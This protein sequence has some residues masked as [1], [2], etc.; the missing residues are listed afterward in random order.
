GHTVA[1]RD[2]PTAATVTK[3][4]ATGQP[5]AG[6][7]YRVEAAEGSAFAD[8]TTERSLVADGDDA[9]GELRGQ[10]VVGD[11]YRMVETAAPA[12]YYLNDEALDFT[13]NRDG[14]LAFD[15]AAGLASYAGDGTASIVQTDVPVALRIQKANAGDGSFDLSG[16]V[17]ALAPAKT[18]AGAESDTIATK[19]TDAQGTTDL[20]VLQ[21][22]A[23]TDYTVTETAA[24][25]GFKLDASPV[26]IHV[27]DDGAVS[28]VGE[29]PAAYTLAKGDDGVWV[30]TCADEPFDLHVQKTDATGQPL[31]GATLD[32][33]GSFADG[34]T[35]QQVVSDAQGM[36]TVGAL[37]VPGETYALAE[38]QA[39][40]GFDALAQPARFTM[41]EAGTL[42]LID[43]ADGR[44]ALGDGDRTLVIVDQ[45]TSEASQPAA[46]VLARTGD[47]APFLP[48]AGLLGSA[49][50]AIFARR[51]LRRREDGDS[52]A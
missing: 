1:V 40:E 31:E 42:T 51:S 28:L 49:A 21:L 35:D 16:A 15:N 19:P 26:T 36:A 25:A 20:S 41:D 32:I 27:A 37:L 8:G 23:H 39:P 11:R 48:L 44:V 14:T 4:D 3:Q 24:P 47:D 50:V 52:Q 6:A 10:L 33:S 45:P 12:G 13:V 43:D 7:T 5:L 30:L 17:F 38:S 46:D 29:A 22:A 34:S 2:V 9:A 18:K